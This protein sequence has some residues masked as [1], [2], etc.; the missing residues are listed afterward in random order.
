M[1]PDFDP[2]FVDKLDDLFV[3]R[4]DVRHFKTTPLADGVLDEVLDRACL[5]PSVG[6]SQPWRFVK[7][8]EGGRRAAVVANFEMCNHQALN[9]YQGEQARLYASLKLAGLK[10]PPYIWLYL[11]TPAQHKALAWGVKPCR[12][13]C[14]IPVCA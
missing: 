9:D 14:I 10:M 2:L 4:R 12:R 6:N 3:W 11:R 5:S 1:S 13:C 8:D 7:V